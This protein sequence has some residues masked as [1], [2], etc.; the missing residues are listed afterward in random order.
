[1][2]ISL[3]AILVAAVGTQTV[4]ADYTIVGTKCGPFNNCHSYN[5]W[6]D[7]YGH[8]GTYNAEEGCRDNPGPPG[9]TSICWDYGNGRGHFY[10]VNQPKRCFTRTFS[11]GV[12]N[13]D[14]FEQ[15]NEVGCSW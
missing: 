1:M 14:A 13:Q 15:W 5:V 9:M 10:Y 11:Y 6:V 8:Y 4:L 2:R 3:P 7:A 12:T